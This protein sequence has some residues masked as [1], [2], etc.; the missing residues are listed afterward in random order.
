MDQF[1]ESFTKNL[2]SSQ[3]Y[4]ISLGLGTAHSERQEFDEKWH[5]KIQEKM[6]NKDIHKIF[7]LIDQQYKEIDIEEDIVRNFND[8]YKTKLKFKFRKIDSTVHSFYCK[9]KN[10]TIYVISENLKSHY[11]YDTIFKIGQN[12]FKNCIQ[13]YPRFYH[14]KLIKNIIKFC[15]KNRQLLYINNNIISNSNIPI[16]YNSGFRF[17]S[18]NIGLQLEYIS[19]LGYILLRLLDNVGNRRLS[20]I[21]IKKYTQSDY[22]ICNLEDF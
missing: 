14:W 6:V 17:V 19:E 15:I 2:H 12:N 20:S 5:K 10:I 18:T 11:K 16:Q 13:S 9:R 22:I 4:I 7:F 1:L 3:E 21:Y 8:Q